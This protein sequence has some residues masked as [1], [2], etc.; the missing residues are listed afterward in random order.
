MTT[1]GPRL[2]DRAPLPPVPFAEPVP[3]I[4][5]PGARRNPAWML[6][7][8][9]VGYPVFWVLG[10]SSFAFT[11]MAVP[12]AA[13]LLRRR[14]LLMPR[15]FVLWGMFLCWSAAGFFLLGVDPTGYVPGSTGGRFIGFAVRE[16]SYVALT[17]VLLF[18]G[19][20]SEEELPQERLVRML[21]W[22]FVTV[23]AGGVLGLLA[24]TFEFR[25]LFEMLLPRSVGSNLYV[26]SLVHPRAAQIQELISDQTPRPAA[27]FSY[28]NVWSFNLTLLGVWFLLARR[29]LRDPLLRS[30]PV[31]VVVVG[32]VVLV[33]SLNRAAWVSVAVAVLYIAVRLALRGRLALV[34]VIVAAVALGLGAVVTTPLGTVV[35]QRLD[36][37]KSDTIREFTT[38]KAFEL[39]AESPVAGFGT[40]RAT[41]GSAASIAVGRSPQCPQCGNANI[42]MNGFLYKLLVTTGY[43]GAVLFFGFGAVVWWRVRRLWTPVALAGTTVLLM[44]LYYSFFYDVS[45]GLLIPFVTL[46]LLWREGRL[47]SARADRA[48]PTVAATA[49]NGSPSMVDAGR[50]ASTDPSSA[51][52]ERLRP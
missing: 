49:T 9:L 11:I 7:V 20:L 45:T 27:P 30:V 52:T 38:R 50:H 10:L 18:V 23:T 2:Q 26:Q 17:V 36:A 13:V 22:F 32:L 4:G 47:A 5:A 25:S 12:M 3:G 40:T 19:N 6:S 28:T 16:T 43:G 24:P 37:G 34:A 21:G 41:Y 14:P 29:Q 46:G 1:G 15:G 33:Y 42:G 35:S 48:S 39:S 8:L 44:T 51:D 31:G